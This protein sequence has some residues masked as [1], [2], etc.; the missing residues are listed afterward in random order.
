VHPV[1]APARVIPFQPDQKPWECVGN[2]NQ[3]KTTGWLEGA[4][5]TKAGG[6]YYLTYSAAGTENRTYAMGCYV[7]A[8]PL[9]PFKLQKRNP[10]LRSTAGLVTGTAHGCIVAGPRNQLWV[11][12][13]VRAGVVH[14]FERRIGLDVAA[15]DSDGELFVPEAT[16]I[17]QRLPERGAR[18]DQPT[19]AGWLS[20]NDGERTL[21]SSNAPSLGGRFAVD[22]N[23]VTWWQPAADDARPVLTT[24]LCTRATVQ[25]VR[26]IW[27]DVGLDTQRGIVPGAFQYRV[28]VETAPDSWTTIL[29]RSSSRR[30]C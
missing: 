12:Y 20:L 19:S 26:I 10:I 6:R 23:L 27:R 15:I 24:N 7:A 2:W 17:P 22:N 25:A 1:G 16:S 18:F 28:E 21:G 29:D 4:W 5:M 9:G 14:G 13:T 30:I 11:F 3:N 8:S